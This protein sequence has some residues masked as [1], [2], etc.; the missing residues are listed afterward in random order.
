MKFSVGEVVVYVGNT[1]NEQC[2]GIIENGDEVTLMRF[3]GELQGY[4]NVWEVDRFARNGARISIP[5]FVLRKRRPPPQYKD[6]H[7]PAEQSFSELISSFKGVG[8]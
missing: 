2:T 1:V 8:V 7:T 3:V 6:Q 4:S 5:E